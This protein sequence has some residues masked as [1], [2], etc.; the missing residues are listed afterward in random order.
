MCSPV[1]LLLI[2]QL[3][4]H[5]AKFLLNVDLMYFP[6]LIFP[7]LKKKI[8]ELQSN[9]FPSSDASNFSCCPIHCNLVSTNNFKHGNCML[10]LT[11]VTPSGILLGYYDL[12]KTLASTICVKN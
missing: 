6:K 1:Y 7:V 4:L 9:T 11:I 12:T 8:V 10:H 3:S 2:Y 5:H